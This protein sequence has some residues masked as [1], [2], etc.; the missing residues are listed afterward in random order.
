M[1]RRILLVILISIFIGN[2]LLARDNK[3][4]VF[5][6]NKKGVT[7]DPYNYFD[8][9]TIDRR[10][11]HGIPLSDS[12]DFPLNDFYVNTIKNIADSISNSS[13]WFNA[14][15]VYATESE[16]T[17]ISKLYFVNSV[18]EMKLFLYAANYK[19]SDWDTAVSPKMLEILVKQTERMGG[20]YF[21]K[22]GIDGRGMRIAI[23]DGGFPT[24]DT[25]PAF[26]HIRKA[27]KI[28]KTW[29]FAKNKDFVYSY[30]SHGTMVLSCIAGIYK[31]KNIGLA[32]GAEFLLARTEIQGEY[33]SEEES[34]LAA[35][36]WADKNGAD[37]INSSLGYTNNRYFP[38]QMDGKTT[39]VTRAANLAAKK[40]I[41]VVNAAGNDGDDSWKIIGAPADA[42]SALSVGG[43][44]PET[45]IHTSFSSYGPTWDKRL[46]PNVCAY[47]HVTAAGKNKMVSTQGTSFASPL[48]AGFAACA[49]QINRGLNN[50]Q[51]F[52]SIEESGDLFPYFDYA[53]GYGVPQAQYFLEHRLTVPDAT[54]DFEFEDGFVKVIVKTEFI[55][56]KLDSS[57]GFLFYNIQ[58][59]NGVLQEYSVI[60]VMQKE[61]LK[62]NLSDYKKGQKLN[63]HLGNYTK[64]FEF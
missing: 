12:T 58:N 60:S 52:Q 27:G 23:F 61:V 8:K 4:W 3:Y 25:N 53:H 18:S 51:M 59:S 19:D 46:K 36:E 37:I 41:L 28:I 2:A 39:L 7:F 16:I 57:K 63:V 56:K 22:A 1:K 9:K 49:W 11:Q 62:L 43:I 32:T 45:D 33:F 64:T 40:G 14:M 42:D 31:G 6:K 21:Q 50:M 47:G 10:L 17:E 29:D 55:D 30:M 44:N 35:V 20:N 54:F 24:V 34:W 48:I 13:R 5:L 15:S 26:E 38:S